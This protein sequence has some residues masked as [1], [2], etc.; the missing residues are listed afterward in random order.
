MSTFA[1]RAPAIPFILITVL[2]D[3]VSV[4]LIIPVLPPLVGQFA[5]DAADH[6]FWYGVVAFAFGISNFFGAPILGRLSDRYGRRPVLLVGFLGLALN[7]FATAMAQ[8]LWVLVVARL[9]GG[10]FQ[11]NAAV[12]HAYVAD[13]SSPEDRARRFGLVGAMFGVGY[14]LGPV[15]GG[16]LGDIDVHLPFY[17]A[18][19]LAVMNT[20][21][22]W[23]VLPESLPQHKRVP[24]EWRKANP[25]SSLRGLAALAGVKPL[26]WVVA[27]SN[28][29]QF[30]LHVTWV[31]Y[32][33]FKFGWG[34]KENG[35]SLFVVGVVAAVVQG[36]LM[37]VLL[38]RFK[39]ERLVQM[40]LVS[41]ATG[42]LAWGLATEGWMMMAIVVCN[43]LGFT[44]TASLQSLISNAVS[45]RE[46]GTAMG[47]V[48]SL[49]SAMAVIAPV[50]GA[51][52]LGLVSP[53]G[54]THWLVG[55][56]FFACCAL[57]I[58]SAVIAIRHFARI[59]RTE[60]AAAFPAAP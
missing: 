31:L 42:Y 29:A 34:P 30:V 7:F 8:A 57:Q 22:G 38:K 55:L 15:M 56:P 13:I 35:W 18:G 5:T 41:S 12:A 11:A 52:L 33:S 24:F 1:G 28:L 53:L 37:R 21:Y 36:G 47:S 48:A 10:A 3:M 54:P 27:L 16:V 2:I 20:L 51:T 50:L 60:Q 26:L 58:C 23:L 59:S 17:V 44:I 9:V 39:P 45:D 43:L 14:V 25:I 40:G 19:A 49:T 6:A 4:G 32:C 46:Q